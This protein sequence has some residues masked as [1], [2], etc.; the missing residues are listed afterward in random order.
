M[1]FDLRDLLPALGFLASLFGIWYKISQDTGQKIEEA[2][3][4]A[5][6]QYSKL[7]NDLEAMR[8]SAIS[9]LEH[10]ND[11]QSLRA[12]IKTFRDEVRDD[13]RGLNSSLT[14][15]FDMMLQRMLDMKGPPGPHK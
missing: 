14:S 5:S 15:R 2:R 3:K 12:E 8:A 1:E 7:R 4:A 6:D 13:I 11:I 9:R 10:D